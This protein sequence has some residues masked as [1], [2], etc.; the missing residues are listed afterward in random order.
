[1]RVATARR[2]A[3][4]RPAASLPPPNAPRFRARGRGPGALRLRPA[5]RD[6]GPKRPFYCDGGGA[7]AGS[8]RRPRV[9]RRALHRASR[10]AAATHRRRSQAPGA[11]AGLDMAG[12]ARGS[13]PQATPQPRLHAR[14]NG[15][16]ST[17]RR[18][19]G[20]WRSRAAPREPRAGEPGGVG[21]ARERGREGGGGGEAGG[22]AAQPAKRGRRRRGGRRRGGGGEG[23]K[24]GAAPCEAPRLPRCDGCGRGDAGRGRARSLSRTPS[25]RDGACGC[26]REEAVDPRGRPRRR[27]PLVPRLPF[28]RPRRVWFCP[29]PSPGCSCAS[30]L[31]SPIPFCRARAC[32][33]A[34]VEKRHRSAKVDSVGRSAAASAA[35]R[36]EGG[37]R[38]RPRRRGGGD[39]RRRPRRGV[40]RGVGRGAS[41]RPLFAVLF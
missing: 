35:S 14:R 8:A 37:E 16:Q 26:R 10:I 23:W 25:I 36:S 34:R 11:E 38:R 12:R 19:V 41:S 24:R 15:P 13:P 33:L 32:A 21:R 17:A 27:R 18:I 22:P 1:M 2:A 40:G 39:A 31:P 4:R 5:T 9:L 28:P 3:S 29:L 7:G 20:L 6:R 30:R